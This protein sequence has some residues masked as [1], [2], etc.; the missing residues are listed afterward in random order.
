MFDIKFKLLN[1]H[2]ENDTA[3]YAIFLQ[4]NL[5]EA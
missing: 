5:F 4:N 1:S 3:P 2:A